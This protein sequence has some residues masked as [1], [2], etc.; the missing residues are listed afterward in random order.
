MAKRGPQPK[1]DSPKRSDSEP[2][3]EASVVL[4]TAQ[5]RFF[6]SPKIYRAFVAGIASGKSWV[7]SADILAHSRSGDLVAV[8]APTFRQLSDSTKRSF[9]ELATK[10][11]LWNEASH[12]KTENQAMLNNGVEVLFRSADDPASNRGPSLSRVWMDEAGLMSEEMFSVMIGRLRQHGRQGKLSATFTPQGKEHWTYRLFSD[13][14][15]PNVELFHCS[16]KDNPFISAEIYQGLADHYGFA[17]VRIA[18]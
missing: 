8:C 9:V 12:R 3:N 5:R 1:Y 11:G 2:N 17:S 15:N 14:D 16:T 4:H 10:W 13:R 18:G 7:G 6:D